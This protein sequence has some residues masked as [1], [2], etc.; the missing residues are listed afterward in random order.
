MPRWD[1]KCEKCGHTDEYAFRNLEEASDIECS[2]CG[3]EMIRQPA[4]GSF[5][6]RGFSYKN[7]YSK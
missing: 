6:I 4:S 3:G 1:F 2:K 5:T 7:G